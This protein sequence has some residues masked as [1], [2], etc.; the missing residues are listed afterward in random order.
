MKTLEDEAEID[1]LKRNA[2]A[3]GLYVNVHRDFDPCRGNGPLYVQHKLRHHS[4][5][6][7]TLLK[8]ASIEQVWQFLG[9][10]RSN[11]NG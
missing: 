6:R 8:Y 9:D 1:L 4:E 2:D 5:P 7:V 11:H 10:Y 3:L